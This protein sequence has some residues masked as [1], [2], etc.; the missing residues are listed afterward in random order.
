M[1]RKHPI[2]I[3]AKQTRYVKKRATFGIAGSMVLEERRV[4]GSR[5]GERASES[6]GVAIEL[7]VQSVV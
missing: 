4:S 5:M 6:E 1:K 7:V 3:K 2:S